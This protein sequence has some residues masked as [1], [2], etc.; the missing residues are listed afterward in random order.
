MADISDAKSDY[1]LVGYDRWRKY[2]ER[3]RTVDAPP[4]EEGWALF[5]DVVKARGPAAPPTPAW[6]PDAETV[7][8][9]NL[10]RWIAEL[11]LDDYRALHAWSVSRRDEFWSAAIDRLGIV[12]H[13]APDAVIGDPGDPLYPSWLAGAR[14]N[15][16][17]SC[18]SRSPER[19]AILAGR[20]DSADLERISYG[21]LEHRAHSVAAALKRQ[22][23]EPGD[24]IALYMP[25]TVDCVAAYLGIVKAG[26]RVV[27]IADSFAAAELARRLRIGSAKTLITVD[28]YSRAGKEIR[29]YDKVREAGAP[30]A[31][32]I[33]D[34][35]ESAGPRL[36][37]GDLAWNDFVASGDEFESAVSDPYDVTNVLFS[38]GTT[39][40]PK[41]IPWTHLTPIKCAMDGRFH[42][43]IRE[44][45]VIAWPTNIGWMMGPWLIYASLLN[46]AAMAL[47]EGAA[48]GVGFRRFVRDA[49]VTMLGTVPSL[50][51]AWQASGD[52]SFDCW[53]GVRVFSST[54][55][56]SNPHDYLWLMSLAGYRAPVIEYCGGTELGGGYITG[57]VVQPASPATFTTPALG[58]DFHILDASGEPVGEGEAGEVFL[59]PPSIGL[60]ETLLNRDHDQIYHANCP[61]GPESRPLRRHGDELVRLP[62]GYF[63]SRGR[64]DDTMNLGGIKV[65]ALELERV[66]DTHPAVYESAAVAVQPGGEGADALVVYVVPSTDA[67]PARL[68]S[69]LGRMIADRLNPLFKLHDL[70]LT[71]WLP[72]TASNKL[73]RREL[74]DRYLASD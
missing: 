40:D 64:A 11:G 73:L 10:G 19:T 3:S 60:S 27:S 36:R 22:G 68:R 7:E 41:A 55:E 34:A 32:V 35:G 49:G 25:M 56:P 23:L 59:A 52:Y 9:S 71:D 63:K 72:R 1:H 62:G 47:Y 74:R 17:A 20:E 44:G 43:D 53:P 5:Q 58:L 70:V 2:V 31:I 30:R 50:V 37:D 21:E 46:G 15:I 65:S 45:D 48:A 24:A 12:F 61:A 33:N 4:F 14:L 13:R 29:L 54:G 6:V 67:D 66:V 16:V 38:S 39:G 51:R 42:H 69:E 28:R 26:C 18:F 57:T 8:S